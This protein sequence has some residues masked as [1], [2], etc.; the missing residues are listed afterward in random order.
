VLVTRH[1]ILGN[2]TLV[3]AGVGPHPGRA[4]RGRRRSSFRRVNDEGRMPKSE[5]MTKPGAPP[6][7][8]VILVSFVIWHSDFVIS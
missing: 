8:F 5:G 6:S 1:G 7:S 4:Q 2:G 3:S